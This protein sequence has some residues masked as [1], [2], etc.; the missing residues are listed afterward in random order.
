MIYCYYCNQITICCIISFDNSFTFEYILSPSDPTEL[1]TLDHFDLYFREHDFIYMKQFS[2]HFKD[3]L[4]CILIGLV[5]TLSSLIPLS[6]TSLTSLCITL[7][8]YILY[9]RKYLVLFCVM[10]ECTA[11]CLLFQALD[12]CILNQG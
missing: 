9:I 8:V 4:G 11:S 1:S 10:V 7:S 5:T 12:I 3:S 2:F 6:V